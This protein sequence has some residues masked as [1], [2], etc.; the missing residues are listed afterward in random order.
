MAMGTQELRWDLSGLVHR[1]LGLCTIW[2]CT[3]QTL[4]NTRSMYPSTIYRFTL[5]G[6]FSVSEFTS[7]PKPA[8]TRMLPQ[9]T[10][11]HA[12]APGHL[13]LIRI[14]EAGFCMLCMAGKMKASSLL[15]A[16]AVSYAV[17][18]SIAC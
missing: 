9:N 1:S 16:I 7:G 12:D 13:A 11:Q 15:M 17:C 6:F 18:H 5:E 3:P 4:M 14:L 2:D 8:S 10:I